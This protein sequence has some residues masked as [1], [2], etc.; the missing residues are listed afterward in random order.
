MKQFKR[1]F[2]KMDFYALPVTL[3]F[4]GEKKFYTNW[5]A[6]TSFAIILVV[7]TLAFYYISQ[8]AGRAENVIYVGETTKVV[9]SK[10]ILLEAGS[11]HEV[12]E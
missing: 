4:K 5:G 2:R 9:H 3:R 1:H 11:T 7:F 10:S 6:C 8:L 12:I